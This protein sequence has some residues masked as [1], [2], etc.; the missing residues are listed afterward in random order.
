MYSFAEKFMD[1]KIV[2]SSVSRKLSKTELQRKNK[3]SDS[4]DSV[5]HPLGFSGK[6]HKPLH[7]FNI[8]RHIIQSLH[9][10]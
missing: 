4:K 10:F 8:T 2:K 1:K 3:K 5:R 9:Y 6:I 7:K